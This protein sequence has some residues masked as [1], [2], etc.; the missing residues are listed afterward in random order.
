MTTPDTAALTAAQ[1]AVAAALRAEHVAEL[2]AQPGLAYGDLGDG[3]Q[4][5]TFDGEHIGDC[6][7]RGEGTSP[8]LNW[9]AYPSDGGPAEGPYLT[10][11][12]GAAALMRLRRRHGNVLTD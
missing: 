7:R 12:Q 1:N 4:Y 11:R 8:L 5:V 3:T 2:L 9:W 10:A 6:R